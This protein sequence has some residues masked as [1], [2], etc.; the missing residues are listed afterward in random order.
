[1]R[2][3]EELERALTDLAAT[4]PDGVGMMDAVRADASRIRQRRRIISISA[5]SAVL[6][7]AIAGAPA[8]ISGLGQR[9]P[10]TAASAY[11]DP[12]QLTVDIAP[13]D[14]YFKQSYRV[15]GSIQRVM[16]KSSAPGPISVDSFPANIF[17]HDP[18]SYDASHLLRGERIT[19]QGRTAYYVPDLPLG[20]TMLPDFSARPSPT[21]D[22]NL[23]PVAPGEVR[24]HA[25]GWQDPT[26]AWVIVTP[27]LTPPDP[28]EALSRFA[29]LVRITPPRDIL[30][31]FSLSYIPGGLKPFSLNTYDRTPDINNDAFISF[32]TPA[33]PPQMDDYE[34]LMGGRP[35]AIRML[36]RS[37]YLDEKTDELGAPT[38]IAGYD[39]W[40][41]TQST[42]TWQ[43][44]DNGSILALHHEDCYVSI[45]VADRNRITLAEL[46]RMLEGTRFADCTDKDT[47][48]RPV[49]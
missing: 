33:E 34:P 38:R 41:L 15:A 21:A 31:P 23:V 2:G 7:V 29:E 47:W 30:A 17:V 28:K 26:G 40:Y 25:V 20:V 19:V 32:G 44:P 13:S 27:V 11:R 4:A 39:A 3:I 6:V 10:D 5:A 49:P 1:M 8:A 48:V 22:R 12:L 36:A 14:R 35:L 43:V 18:G 16:V 37:S 45:T 46:T 24:S 42:K 9:A